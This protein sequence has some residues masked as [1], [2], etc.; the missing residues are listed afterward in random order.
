M[1]EK[2]QTYEEMLTEVENIITELQSEE[3]A[4]DRVISMVKRGYSLL[5][6]L[7]RRLDEVSLQ[8]TDIKDD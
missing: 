4:L 1:T 2:Q 5:S 3:L 8:I 6:E 7:K